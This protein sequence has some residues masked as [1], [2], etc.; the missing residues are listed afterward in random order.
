MQGNTILDRAKGAHITMASANYTPQDHFLRAKEVW[1]RLGISKSTFYDLI[2]K[3][4]FPKP[5]KLG[6]RTSVWQNSQVEKFMDGIMAG[7][8]GQN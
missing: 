3:G 7:E 4:K 6:T 1:P 8:G 5:R 2:S